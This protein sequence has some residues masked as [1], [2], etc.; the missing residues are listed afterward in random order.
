[1]RTGIGWDVHVLEEGNKGLVIGNVVV[2]KSVSCRAHSDGDVLIHAVIDSLLGACGMPDIGT[3]FPDTDP[4]YKNINSAVLLEKT[5][6]MV[7]KA[8]Y[9]IENIDSVVVLQNIKLAPYI[10]EMKAKL[11]NIMKLDVSQIGIKTKTAECILGELG[12]GSA[13]MAQAVCLV[14]AVNG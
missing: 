11:S 8:G 13:V 2:E 14:K 7:L 12:N 10:P 6:K 3:L 9:E 4:A 5:C 1:M